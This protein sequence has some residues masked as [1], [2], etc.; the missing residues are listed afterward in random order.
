MERHFVCNSPMSCIWTDTAHTDVALPSSLSARPSTSVHRGA[1]SIAAVSVLSTEYV[2][3]QPSK[4][5]GTP[6]AHN[7]VVEMRDEMAAFRGRSFLQFPNLRREALL[8]R[9]KKKKKSR[10]KKSEE[11]KV[12]SQLNCVLP[13]YPP[14]S[15]IL[16]LFALLFSHGTAEGLSP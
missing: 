2:P 7:A 9:E 14:F 15:S 10:G 4:G 3:K 12:K 11:E 6:V 1:L 16:P 8:F 5:G 13:F